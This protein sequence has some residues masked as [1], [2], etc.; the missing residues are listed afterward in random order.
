MPRLYIDGS[1]ISLENK[2]VGRYSYELCR[3]VVDKL[4]SN[5][6]IDVVVYTDCLPD[7]LKNNRRINLV[8]T[9]VMSDFYHNL[10][11]LPRQ[12]K[13]R[14]YDLLVKP[15]ESAGLG[16]EV[17][18]ITVCH[19]VQELIDQAAD[20]RPGLRQ[21][22]VNFL[23][24]KLKSKNLRE[25]D[26]VVCNSAFTR[27]A[28][29]TWYG[30]DKSKTIIGYC[31]VDE[32]FFK[33][34]EE[35]VT[36]K[37]NRNFNFENFVLTFA[38]GD[39]RENHDL[40]PRVLH[41][42]RRL[43]CGAKMIVAGVKENAEYV[44]R[45]DTQFKQLGLLP[46]EDYQ[47]VGFLGEEKLDELIELYAT[48]DFYLEL[49]G[50]EGFGMQLAEAMAC[51]TTCVSSGKTALAEVGAGFDVRFSSFDPDQI[52]KAILESYNVKLH[53]RSN[54]AQVAYVHEHYTWDA[55]SDLVVQK[56]DSLVCS[57]R[58]GPA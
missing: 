35:F 30:L 36:R 9:P 48:A 37:R 12:I 4:S 8:R 10:W 32:R 24:R 26:V 55:V 14:K 13:E 50:H 21:K 56:I 58:Q 2:G 51:G 23:K 52:A 1:A 31:G 11:W 34:A 3:R 38:T 40:I 19:D 53:E 57:I 46:V 42:L 29:A 18:T 7:S 6:E 28:A 33:L 22:L 17:P 27:D 15:M 25:S 39:A 44:H 45:M 16:Y 41:E 54:G 43:G 20:A 49:S 47:Y 5:W